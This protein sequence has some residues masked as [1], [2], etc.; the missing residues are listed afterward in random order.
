M[1]KSPSSLGNYSPGLWVQ[2][3]DCRGLNKYHYHGEVYMRYGI[4]EKY[5]EYLTVMLLA[6]TLR[7]CLGL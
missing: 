2:D 7:L 1:G 4:L 6:L 3:L 5:T